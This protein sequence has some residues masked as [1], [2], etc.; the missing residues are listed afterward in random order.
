MDKLFSTYD[1]VQE[2]HE[3]STRASLQ[4]VYGT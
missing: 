2:W 4:K 1:T 3:V